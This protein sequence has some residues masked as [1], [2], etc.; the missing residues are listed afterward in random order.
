MLQG[1]AIDTSEL[2]YLFLENLAARGACSF[3][4]LGVR[5]SSVRFSQRTQTLAQGGAARL[6]NIQPSVAQILWGFGIKKK[7]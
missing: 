5:S 3:S 6:L 2:G 4:L 7:Y 1:A